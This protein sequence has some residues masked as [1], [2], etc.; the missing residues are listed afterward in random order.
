MIPLYRLPDSKSS[1]QSNADHTS[2]EAPLANEKHMH[3]T[4]SRP[5]FGQ[6]HWPR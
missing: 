4:T 5:F 6:L 2:L 1:A 3:A